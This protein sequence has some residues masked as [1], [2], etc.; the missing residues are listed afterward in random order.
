M[1]ATF[2]PGSTSYHPDFFFPSFAVLRG[3]ESFSIRSNSSIEKHNRVAT[4]GASIYY[5]T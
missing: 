3:E 1:L 4:I 2:P 5:F